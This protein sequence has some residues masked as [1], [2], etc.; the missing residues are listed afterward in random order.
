MRSS[1]I[2]CCIL[3]LVAGK[4]NSC[5]L[6]CDSLPPGAI[7]YSDF[8]SNVILYGMLNDSIPMKALLDVGAW[9]I[10]VPAVANPEGSKYVTFE[11]NGLKKRMQSSPMNENSQFLNWYGGHCVLLGWDFFDRRILEIS[12]KDK[13]IR[14]LKRVELD[15]LKAG[16]DSIKFHNRGRRLIVEGTVNIGDK[17][18]EG[19]FWMDTGLNGLLFFTDDIP[20]KYGFDLNKTKQG[21]AKNMDSGLTR[22]N[23][24]RADTIRIGNSCITGHDVIFADSEWFVFR[25]NELYIGL[26]GNQFFK[27]FSVIFD[28]RQNVLYLKSY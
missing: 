12:Y 1:T 3:L 7:P 17:V 11:I 2:I 27:K 8:K 20:A 16:Y 10:A 18:I 24:L 14:M 22:V 13:Y 28:F 19:N 26:I 4:I 25:K 6:S 9:G 15:S 5:G 21:R 23:M